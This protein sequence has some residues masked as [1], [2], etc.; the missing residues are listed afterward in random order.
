M[1]FDITKFKELLTKR[2]LKGSEC[3]VVY[4]QKFENKMNDHDSLLIIRTL[5]KTESSSQAIQ[6]LSSLMQ[7]YEGHDILNVFRKAFILETADFMNLE[8]D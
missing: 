7:R 8:D 6:I 3:P 2:N 1:E 5:L 4:F